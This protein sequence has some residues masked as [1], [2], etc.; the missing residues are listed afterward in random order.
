[1]SNVHNDR[2]NDKVKGFLL[3]I[4]GSLLFLYSLNLVTIGITVLLIAASIG[5][6]LYGAM[7]SGLAHAIREFI[8]KIT[9]SHK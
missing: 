4:G 8:E 7:I 2:H 6:I 1:M 5:L 3:L 9:T